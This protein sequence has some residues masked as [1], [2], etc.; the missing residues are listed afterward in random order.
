MSP[1][2]L[3]TFDKHCPQYSP[4]LKDKFDLYD[5]HVFDVEEIKEEVDN[6]EKQVTKKEYESNEGHLESEREVSEE[7]DENSDKEEN[8][9]VIEK[10]SSVKNEK[11]NPVRVID[12]ELLVKTIK[13]VKY[14]LTCIYK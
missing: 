12:L 5:V 3:R 2:H 9:T 1:D 10:I 6:L 7:A 14:H 4:D 11:Y 8:V 13:Y